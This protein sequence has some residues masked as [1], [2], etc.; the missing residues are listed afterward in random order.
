MVLPRNRA[1]DPEIKGGYSPR[2]VQT[3]T[4]TGLDLEGMNRCHAGNLLRVRHSLRGMPITQ[5]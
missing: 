3:P 2:I 1:L 4:E 5:D